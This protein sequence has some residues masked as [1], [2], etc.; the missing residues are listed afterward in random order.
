MPLQMIFFNWW[1]VTTVFAMKH[2]FLFFYKRRLTKAFEALWLAL[3]TLSSGK[4]RYPEVM[5]WVKIIKN[6]VHSFQGM[7]DKRNTF[8][9][10]KWFSLTRAL[11]EW[12]S[13]F[14][15]LS[16]VDVSATTGFLLRQLI[17]SLEIMIMIEMR[18]MIS[19]IVGLVDWK[20]LPKV[21]VAVL[22]AL[23]WFVGNFFFV[24]VQHPI[25]KLLVTNN[26]ASQLVEFKL[27]NSN[28][29][30]YR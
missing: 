17:S 11:C 30:A 8:E 10:Q 4:S 20:R 2:S 26:L 15:W 19:S 16:L 24:T 22:S 6:N 9:N 1:V 23:S 25:F 29:S 13:R 21:A 3:V 12:S 18:G 7:S 28:T 5:L 27:I 14:K